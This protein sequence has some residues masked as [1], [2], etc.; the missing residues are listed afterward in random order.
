LKAAGSKDPA[1]FVL[2]CA[3][4]HDELKLNRMAGRYLVRRREAINPYR[5]FMGTSL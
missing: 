1:V 4:R 3:M 5:T 2:A